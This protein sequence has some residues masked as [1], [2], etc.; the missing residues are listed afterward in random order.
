MDSDGSLHEISRCLKRLVA[1]V[2]RLVIA[3]SFSSQDS[4]LT[5]GGIYRWVAGCGFVLQSATPFKKNQNQDSD[6]LGLDAHRKAL[7][8]NTARFLQGMPANHVLLWGA[9]GT[10]KSSIVR[11][12]IEQFFVQDL[13]VLDCSYSD[14][15]QL[16]VMVSHINQHFSDKRF[17][18]YFDDLSFTVQK[19][20]FKILKSTMEGSLAGLPNNILIYATSNRRHLAPELITDTQQ[21]NKNELHLHEGAD[22]LL[23]L[24]ERFGLQLAFHKNTQDQYLAVV[25]HW[26]DKMHGV[27][28]DEQLRQQ[29]L[30]WSLLRGSTSGRVAKQFVNAREEYDCASR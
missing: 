24:T 11:E 25:S 28:L 14:I 15:A 26:L 4:E 6:L 21:N 1:V 7:S 3:D 29:A 16:P 27:T 19:M 23:A 5:Q 17:I 12:V 2:E 10:G 22:E 30:Q 13:Y 20:E 8:N 9:K 18:F